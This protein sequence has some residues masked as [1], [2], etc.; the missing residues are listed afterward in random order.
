VVPFLLFALAGFVFGYAIE[1]RWAFFALF[2]PIGLALIAF[3]GGDFDPFPFVVALI[4]TVV[5]VL[6]GRMLAAATADRT[7]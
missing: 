7:A 6:L 2:F 1:S 5:A 4:L 3:W